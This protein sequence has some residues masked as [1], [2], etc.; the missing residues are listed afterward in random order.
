[1]T[2]TKSFSL[3]EDLAEKIERF[4]RITRRTGSAVAVMAFEDFMSREEVQQ[5]LTPSPTPQPQPTAE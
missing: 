4:A 3:P 5:V 2:E 1:M